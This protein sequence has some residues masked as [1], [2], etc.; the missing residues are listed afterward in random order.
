M[1]MGI[2]APQNWLALSEAERQTRGKID[3]D[4]CVIGN[5]EFYVRGCLEI[6]VI[7]SDL[8]FVW[9][10]WISVSKASWDRI[11]ELWQ[12][13]DVSDEPPRF[14][15]L[16][17]WIAGY[18]EPREIKCHLHIRPGNLRPAIELQPTDYPLAIEQ[19]EGIS[20]ERVMEIVSPIL[21][22]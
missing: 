22:Q 7:G 1:D 21:H 15:W 11:L 18:P 17:N 14:G 12:A 9:G 2:S 16:S 8:P 20:M 10:V 13:D 19:R 6:P 3:A 5:R 4:L